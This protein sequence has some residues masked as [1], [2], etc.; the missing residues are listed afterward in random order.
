MRV[1]DSRVLS[2]AGTMLAAALVSA[3][4]S[5]GSSSSIPVSPSSLMLASSSTSAVTSARSAVAGIA[6]AA[7]AVAAPAAATFTPN[8]LGY[9]SWFWGDRTSWTINC[10]KAAYFPPNT[11]LPVHVQAGVTQLDGPPLAAGVFVAIYA[12][13]ATASSS[14]ITAQSFRTSATPFAGS[15]LPNGYVAPTPAPVPNYLGYVSWFWGDQTSWTINCDKPTYFPPKTCLPVKVPAGVKQLDGPPL[16]TGIFVAILGTS[17]TTNGSTGLT[18]QWFRTSKTPFA[19]SPLPNGYATPAPTATPTPQPS[20]TPTPK[21]TATPTPKPTATP[22]PKPTATPPPP[23]PGGDT[24]PGVWSQVF[25]GLSPFHETVA[26]LKAVGASTLSQ[27]AMNTLWSQGVSQQDLS[28]SGYYSPIYVSSA[29]DPV[30]TFTCT[31]YGLCNANGAQ[32]HVPKNAKIEPHSDGHIGIVDTAKGIEYDGWA[33]S[34]GTA[35]L[36]CTWGGLFPFT[37]SGL[38]ANGNSANHAGFTSLFI[39]TPQ[40]LANG[41]IDHALGINT[42]CL[43]GMGV[44]PAAL[45]ATDQGCGGSGA[46]VY[47]DLVHLLWTP[48][49]IASSAYSNECKTILTALATYGAYTKDTGSDGLSLSV[50]A[51]LAYTALGQTD[52]YATTILPHLRAAG[53]ANGTY[54]AS[55]LNRLAASDLELLQIPSGS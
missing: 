53:D 4:G 55:C 20:A 37:G 12:D 23:N 44:Y 8:Y 5:G 3:C 25:T 29:S 54:W 41:H 18:V 26:H 51:S 2:V 9:V 36:N 15:T 14:G 16:A 33:C 13:P 39:I 22:T 19:G 45:G 27:S 28:P 30:M 35:S 43:N 40:E 24:L 31:G 48:A 34:F 52:P 32:I 49:Q 46:P 6:T 42:V 1:I 11:C 21:P 7:G 17:A 47:G 38:A 10:D 50:N